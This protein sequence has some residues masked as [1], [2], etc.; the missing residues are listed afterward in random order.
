MSIPDRGGEPYVSLLVNF[1]YIPYLLHT[2]T[3]FCKFLWKFSLCFCLFASIGQAQ[4]VGKF[5]TLVT[6][7]DTTRK[8]SCYVPADYDASKA[9][10]LII[11]LHGLG[12]NATNYRNALVTSLNWATNFPNTIFICPEAETVNSDFFSPVGGEEIIQKS[13]DFVMSTYHIDTA[14]VILQGFS[15]GG[16]AALRY[17]L[18]HPEKFKGLL[19]NT[20]AI[21]GVKNALNEQPSYLYKYESARNVPIYITHGAKDPV[22]TAPIDSA[23]KQMILQ[24]GKVIL[25]R[26]PTLAHSIPSFNR[27]SNVLQFFE[28]PALT[29]IDVQLVE[30]EAP[31]RVCDAT[32]SPRMLI[33]NMGS[34][35]TSEIKI[36]YGS[37][38]S[39][40]LELTMQQA[41]APFEHAYVTLA[42]LGFND[43]E[44]TI[45]ARVSLVNGLADTTV[46]NNI[47]GD[48]LEA[49]LSSKPLPFSESFSGSFPP[50]GWILERSGDYIAGFDLD[51]ETGSDAPGSIMAINTIFIFDNAG[52]Q[53]AILTPALDLTTVDQPSMLFDMAFNFHRYTPPYFTDTVDFADTLEIL[54][55]TD[56]GKLWQQLFRK[57]GADL[58]TFEQPI[59]NPLSLAEDFISPKAADWRRESIDLTG[60]SAS[61]SA[62]IKFN[63]ISALG[64]HLYIDNVHIQGVSGVVDD[65]FITRSWLHPNPASDHLMIAGLS[66]FSNVRVLDIMGREVLKGMSEGTQLVLNVQS[67]PLGNYLLHIQA[68]G[69][70]QLQK[71][72][73]QR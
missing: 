57:G 43:G 64:G 67:L 6:F 56:C 29:P 40:A 45:N 10:R 16:R 42:D 4:Q 36:A 32:L 72:S 13:M 44:N 53:D 22:Y 21:Q 24:N 47:V 51:D 62:V 8:L 71:F 34:D 54:I 38:G 33:R 48:T 18:E 28:N 50:S 68:N 65:N 12:D 70:T 49:A 30:I 55:S 11:G 1:S 14:N 26:Y 20:P 5:D 9:Y 25:T 61:K 23:V 15:L 41:L 46:A 58:A 59:I 60:F 66:H 69:A 19:L 63:Y 2:M 7:M 39:E 17:G 35:P 52:K 3:S 73:I 31:E 37:N 27:M